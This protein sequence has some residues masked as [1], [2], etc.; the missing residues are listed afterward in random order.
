M[1][2]GAGQ[3]HG[4]RTASFGD[5]VRR[6]RRVLDLT[7]AALAARVG[8]STATVKKIEQDVRRPSDV[9]AARLADALDIPHDQREA[10]VA[11]G[12]GE[13]ATARFLD[14]ARQGP[15]SP[16]PPV[17]GRDTERATLHRHLQE[18]LDAGARTVFLLGEAGQGKTALLSALAAD[19][20]T[21]NDQVVV[22]RGQGTTANG[23]GDPYLLLRDVL[24]GL[25]RGGVRP[26]GRPPDDTVGSL[27]HAAMRQV[28]P[29]A[30]RLVASLLP[31]PVPMTA[32][33][34]D[35]LVGHTVSLL[36]TVAEH[37]P[38]L[39]VL[40]DLQWSDAAS[41]DLL[42]HLDRRLGRAP[43]LIV[44]AYRASDVDNTDG[45]AATTLRQLRLDATAADPT[46][47]LDLSA[48]DATAARTLCQAL[49][50]HALG[51]VDDDLAQVLFDRTH[52]HPLFVLELIRE[53][54]THDGI[55][56]APNGTWGVSADLDRTRLPTR[57]AAVIAQRLDRLTPAHRTL[58]DVA[59]VEGERFTAEVVAAVTG[60]DVLD[61]CRT[62]DGE[63][64]GDHGLVHSLP[65]DQPSDLTGYRFR[66]VLFQQYLD[67]TLGDGERRHLHRRVGQALLDLHDDHDTI[68][69]RLAHHFAMAHDREPA[70]TWALRSGD[71]ARAIYAHREAILHYRR[72]TELLRD[73]DDSAGL[74]RALIKLG[75]SHQ[76]AFQHDAAQAAYDEAFRLWHVPRPGGPTASATLR[77]VWG[78]PSSLDPTM[79][80]YNT[81][82]PITTQLFSGLVAWGADNEVVPDIA[83]AW[84][85][86]DGG[87][88][89]VFHLR[90][91][92][93]WHDGEPVTAHDV[94]FTFRRA[95]EP[96][97]GAPVAPSLLSPVVGAERLHA[98]QTVA[99]SDFGVRALDDHTL[100]IDLQQ[101][102]SWF[103]PNLAYYVLLPTPAHVVARHGPA[104][105]D[106][107]TFVGNGPFRLE[108]WDHGRSLVLARN[109]DHHGPSTG[110]VARVELDLTLTGDAIVDAYQHDRLD[111]V[112]SFHVPP[113]YLAQLGRQHPT[114][115]QHAPAFITLLAMAETSRAPMDDPRVR[116][117]LAHAIDRRA[118]VQEV[119]AGLGTPATGGVVPRGM[120]GH[121]AG[122]ATPYDPAAAA[123][124]LDEAGGDRT[125]VVASTRRSLAG[126][127]LAR[128]LAAVGFDVHSEVVDP[129]DLNEVGAH[130][131]LGGWIADY[132]DPDTFLRVCLDPDGSAAWV[133]TEHRRLLDEAARTTDQ[134]HR[135][136]LYAQVERL[137][138][139][140]A[141]AI[142]LAYEDWTMFLKPWVHGFRVPAI[143]H[144]GFWQD[145]RVGPATA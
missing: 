128:S 89:M 94:V 140:Q 79:G 133:T 120:P 32:G 136:S 14:R 65:G 38:L 26:P 139:D 102:T 112:S 85:L 103:L 36:R 11:A 132:P 115:L 82:A 28:A 100:V 80:G 107:A 67:D 1:G 4:R 16:R 131:L 25:L 42:F 70:I 86:E 8:C 121:V 46:R 137:L 116:R 5:L 118:F 105:A 127:F 51:Q 23:S 117:A 12:T 52:G 83:H 20:H 95:L 96:S 98:G 78:E 44:G 69:P 143:K 122:I 114:E 2:A 135:L 18:T 41:M 125:I 30:M 7:Q 6:R 24:E 111:I 57:V 126:P 58:L 39:L 129:A 33:T 13:I 55:Q 99:A 17:V 66:H 71:R 35:D 90:D 54:R 47:V 3:G 119:L 104:W 27:V 21:V 48:P 113:R 29:G 60:R 31:D 138:A 45:P 124:L 101:P 87:R 61:V 93:R 62:L 92:V 109:P 110:N 106:P 74:A 91:D 88:R 142:P 43:V 84:R 37:R 50:A 77:M 40:D 56:Q 134:A 141:V 64:G 53:L 97:T 10:F 19:A 130:V 63:L 22:A 76:I 123:R 72:A 59:A 108:R 49:T 81:T 15:T 9:M 145:I 34:S 75:L 73:T 144:P 68:A